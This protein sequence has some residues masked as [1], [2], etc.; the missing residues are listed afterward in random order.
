MIKP[1]Q[2][3]IEYLHYM[4]GP[5]GGRRISINKWL[6]FIISCNDSYV[7]YMCLSLTI[8]RSQLVNDLRIFSG[9]NLES[10]NNNVNTG[11]LKLIAQ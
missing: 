10:F 5:G 4:G 1:G 7:T 6:Y 11:S 9:Y 3:F 2:L 8:A